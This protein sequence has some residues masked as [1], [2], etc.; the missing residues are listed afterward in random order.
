MLTLKILNRSQKH[1]W[2]DV[3]PTSHWRGLI[4]FRER[5]YVKLIDIKPHQTVVR[6]YI[7]EAHY[8]TVDN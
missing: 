4:N 8:T 1:E 2:V 5:M 6:R 7:L 3:W